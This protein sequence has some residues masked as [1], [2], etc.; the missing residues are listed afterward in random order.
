LAA[1]QALIVIYTDFYPDVARVQ[2]RLMLHFLPVAAAVIGWSC[3]CGAPRPVVAG[4]IRASAAAP[5]GHDEESRGGSHGQ[6]DV[7]PAVAG[8]PLLGQGRR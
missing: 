1:Y 6:A 4:P 8:S 2:Y 5:H 7:P 3:G